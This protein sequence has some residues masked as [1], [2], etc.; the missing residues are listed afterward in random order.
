MNNHTHT[1]YTSVLRGNKSGE[2]HI[3]FFLIFLEN[4][5]HWKHQLPLFSKC[6]WKEAPNPWFLRLQPEGS[7]NSPILWLQPEGGYNPLCSPTTTER[8]LQPPILA[9]SNRPK[10]EV[11]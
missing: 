9:P 2:N 10:V 3:M 8:W 1:Q 4:Y 11:E 6:N 7:F 5:I